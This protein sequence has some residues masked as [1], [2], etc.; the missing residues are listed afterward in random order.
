MDIGTLLGLG[1]DAIYA[2]PDLEPNHGLGFFPG[3]GPSLSLSSGIVLGVKNE[4]NHLKN[5]F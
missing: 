4:R 1:P 3:R 5:R 2:N